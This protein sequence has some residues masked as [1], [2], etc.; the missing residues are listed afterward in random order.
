VTR[1]RAPEAG[2]RPARPASEA[3]PH[4]GGPAAPPLPAPE[5][6]VVDAPAR[7]CVTSAL[8]TA[9]LVL[10]GAAGPELR[11]A[12]SVGTEALAALFVAQT[13]G[14]LV[15]AALAARLA[16]PLLQP[17]PVAGATAAALA[18]AAAAPTAW[19]LGAAMAVAGGGAFLLVTTAQADVARRSPGARGRALSRFHVWGATGGLLTPLALSAALG[20]DASWRAGFA[21]V[22]AAYLAHALYGSARIVLRPGPRTTRATRPQLT[23]RARWSVVVPVAGVGLQLTLALFLAALL[24][25]EWGA[26]ASAGSAVVALYALGLLAARVTTARLGAQVEGRRP[27]RVSAVLLLVGYAVLALAPSGAVAAL[28]AVLLGAGVGP[29]LPLGMARAAAELGDD[30]AASALVFALNGVAQVVF[31]AV[32][33]ALLAIV[34]LRLALVATAIIGGVVLLAVRRSEPPLAAA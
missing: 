18:L 7:L 30:R 20:A 6:H 13:L 21:L 15:G 24:V 12:F 33:V 31:P 34:D 19:V 9:V 32:V 17:L 14:T 29:L 2:D 3:A 27:L 25:D 23:A 1:P 11:V 8:A 26:S 10:V 22:A 28:A 5:E 16:D 4:A